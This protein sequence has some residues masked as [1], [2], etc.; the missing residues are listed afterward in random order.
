MNPQT[1]GHLRGGDPLDGNGGR[2]GNCRVPLS[3]PL[4][5]GV[6]STGRQARV[7]IAQPQPIIDGA[8]GHLD[9]LVGLAVTERGRNPAN[10][11]GN[12]PIDSEDPRMVDVMRLG[13]KFVVNT[14]TTVFQGLVQMAGLAD[15]AFA[16]AWGLPTPAPP[17]AIG[18][19]SVRRASMC[20]AESW[21]SRASSTQAW[22]G[23][24]AAPQRQCLRIGTSWPT[25]FIPAER[26][27]LT[28]ASVKASGLRGRTLT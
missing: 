19:T 12:F 15:G 1:I 27:L 2:H 24:R 25:A 16:M 6:P 28:G 14:V 21:G 13:P 17:T 9:D 10:H 26:T 4:K 3:F 22:P 11:L 8:M 23:P 7:Q 18:P 20:T 5:N